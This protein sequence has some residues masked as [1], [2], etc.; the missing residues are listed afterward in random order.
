MPRPCAA[1][2]AAAL[3]CQ[4]AYAGDSPLLPMPDDGAAKGPTSLLL[5]TSYCYRARQKIQYSPTGYWA[6]MCDRA[7]DYDNDGCFDWFHAEQV[8]IAGGNYTITD[9]C[10]EECA[11]DSPCFTDPYAASVAGVSIQKPATPELSLRLDRLAPSDACVD[12]FLL[13]KEA[14]G[15][16][17][18]WPENA[19]GFVVRIMKDGETSWDVKL[20]PMTV[21]VNTDG[22][23][24][25]ADKSEVQTLR[26]GFQIEPLASGDDPLF[27]AKLNSLRPVRD[28]H[29]DLQVDGLYELRLGKERF[30]VKMKDD[31][32]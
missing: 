7:P 22:P 1:L 23:G 30:F 17:V 10:V 28:P 6:W 3:L 31:P 24:G 19:T 9:T 8:V 26:L 14:N 12:A 32:V 16:V 21:V 11:C 15:H 27:T 18:V 29:H 2:L 13:P 5:T 20:F 4:A 25:D